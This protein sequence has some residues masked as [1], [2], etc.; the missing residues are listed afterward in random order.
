MNEKIVEIF[1][2]FVYEL[3]LDDELQ[4]AR[5]LRKKLINKLDIKRLQEL[6]K[7]AENLNKLNNEPSNKKAHLDFGDHA[8]IKI[9]IT[10]YLNSY[11]KSQ[12]NLLCFK[13]V[14]LAEQMTLIDLNLFLKIELSEVLLWSTK[15]NEEFSPNLIQFTEHFNNISYWARSRILEHSNP[16]EREKYIIKFLKI[17]KHL[18]KINNF[19]SYLS[20]LSAV[21]SG[22]IQRLDW[23]KSVNDVRLC[24]LLQQYWNT[25]CV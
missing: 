19:N 16:K 10:P 17:M 4:L 21:D 22:P 7:E 2:D 20:L 15:Q 24:F 25:F 11:M 13:S 5:L 12:P 9:Q 6:E 1:A 18:R 14:D 23:P 3:L 8:N